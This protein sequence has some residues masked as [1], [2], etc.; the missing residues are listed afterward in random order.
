MTIRVTCPG[1]HKRFDVSE[2]YAGKEGPCPKC[3]QVIKIPNKEDEVVIHAPDQ[4]GPKDAE[5]KSTLAPIERDET[6]LSGVQ[7]TLICVTVLGFFAGSLIVRLMVDDPGKL[8]GLLLVVGALFI[9]VPTVFGGYTFLRDQERGRFMGQSL[10]LRVAVCSVLYV[11]LWAL[12][13]LM[14]YA[15][16]G[17]SLGAWIAAGVGMLALGAAIGMFSLDL[18]YLIGLLHFGMYFG[19]CLLA[20]VIVGVGVFPGTN[21]QGQE[22]NTTTISAL[23]PYLQNFV[24]AVWM[25]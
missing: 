15:F 9:S 25:G 10:I 23:G 18:D 7:I 8:S 17:Y 3:K 6:T 12:F 24:G 14:E 19:C 21:E 1:C 2:K 4:S 11:L 5:G 13:P 16:D 20:R 22:L